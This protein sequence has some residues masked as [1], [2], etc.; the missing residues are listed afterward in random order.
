MSVSGPRGKMVRQLPPLAVCAG[1]LLYV[2]PWPGRSFCH[3]RQSVS[4]AAW[5]GFLFQLV[6]RFIT[7][8]A[9]ARAAYF[10]VYALSAVIPRHPPQKRTSG[11]AYRCDVVWLFWLLLHESLYGFRISARS[12]AALQVSLPFRAVSTPS[13]FPVVLWRG[14]PADAGTPRRPAVSRRVRHVGLPISWCGII[15]CRP[16]RRS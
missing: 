16:G 8:S 5:Q 15:P 3:G 12:R 13:L 4:G 14:T 10:A 11:L 7:S 9:A 1:F 2:H 6:R